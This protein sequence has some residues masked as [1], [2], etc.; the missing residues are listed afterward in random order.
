MNIYPHTGGGFSI[1]YDAPPLI[2]TLVPYDPS[3]NFYPN[4]NHP[5]YQYLPPTGGGFSIRYDAPPYQVQVSV[6]RQ[7]VDKPPLPI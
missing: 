4:P 5:P 2:S 1:R 6:S 3:T 7:R